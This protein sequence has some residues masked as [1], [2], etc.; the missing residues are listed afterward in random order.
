MTS[1]SVGALRRATTRP[2]EPTCA[3]R[4]SL[5]KA[6]SAEALGYRMTHPARAEYT[7]LLSD[8]NATSSFQHASMAQRLLARIRSSLASSRRRFLVGVFSFKFQL[9]TSR[10]I[11]LKARLGE[12][13]VGTD[14]QQFKFLWGGFAA[15]SFSFKSLG[16]D[17]QQGHLASNPFWADLQKCNLASNPFGADLQ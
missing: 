17:L 9:V 16:A 7:R 6:R 15:V 12:F 2:L 4:A 11:S 3:R 14:F 5:H 1:H 8:V 10:C 13:A